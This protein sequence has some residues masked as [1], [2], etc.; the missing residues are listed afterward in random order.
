VYSEILPSPQLSGFV[1]CFWK[2]DHGAEDAEKR[3]LPDGCVDVLFDLSGRGARE[4][5]VVGAMTRA[6][7]VSVR[8]NT[9]IVGVRFRP[10]G[11]FPLLKVPMDALTDRHIDLRA[12]WRDAG[13]LWERMGA[14]KDL[15]EGVTVL[16]AELV[17]RLPAAASVEG[18]VGQAIRM[19]AR[20]PAA[21]SVKAL[22]QQVGVSRQH[23]TRTF[24][25]RVGLGPKMLARVLRLR[26]LI[27]SL[28]GRADRNWAS[29]AL[30]AGYYD[31]SH[32]TAEC[33]DLTGLT[34]ARL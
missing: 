9:R 29:L 11:A 6:T 21:T 17:S 7:L 28:P 8:T 14:A 24:R 3:V 22:A 10:G 13:S 20:W 4:P 33:R 23:L 32:L 19:I 12:L 16:D 26:R 31:Q 15:V 2:I 18:F 30:D 25:A 5:F 34:P 27:E 1:E